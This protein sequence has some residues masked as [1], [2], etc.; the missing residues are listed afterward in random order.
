VKVRGM[1]RFTKGRMRSFDSN[2]TLCFEARFGRKCG[3]RTAVAEFGRRVVRERL[4]TS[5]RGPR[6]A[7]CAT[8]EASF[9]IVKSNY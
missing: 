1:P 2:H 7:L 5:S 8:V 4:V 3:V 9:L 6:C